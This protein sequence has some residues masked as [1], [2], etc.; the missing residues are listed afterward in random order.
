M[1]P[2]ISNSTVIRVLPMSGIPMRTAK[3]NKTAGT[4]PLKIDE[5]N[6]MRATQKR[7]A[8][9]SK[10]APHKNQ[11]RLRVSDESKNSSPGIRVN[12]NPKKN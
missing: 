8:T 9:N 7:P 4:E 11:L 10:K 3:V 12:K 6:N 1:S 2:R 5:V